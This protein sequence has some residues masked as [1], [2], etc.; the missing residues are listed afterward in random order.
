MEQPGRAGWQT[1]HPMFLILYAL[2]FSV[3]YR[4]TWV[5]SASSGPTFTPGRSIK[6]CMVAPAG[7]KSRVLMFAMQCL[8]CAVL[9]FIL[10][11]KPP[12]PPMLR[13]SLI[14]A[15]HLGPCTPAMASNGA[16]SYYTSTWVCNN[17]TIS[18]SAVPTSNPSCQ[19]VFGALMSPV[20]ANHQ[21][22]SAVET[23]SFIRECLVEWASPVHT[24]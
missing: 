1:D 5:I 24:Y 10:A 18:H 17:Y 11:V 14:L 22:I 7:Y 21:V 8:S 15:G 20:I 12:C 19:G 3:S 13:D 23:L 2:Q 6:F 9:T 4:H 16:I